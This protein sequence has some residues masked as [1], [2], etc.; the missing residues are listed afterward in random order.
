METANQDQVLGSAEPKAESQSSTP[1]PQKETLAET[2]SGFASVFVAGLFI[3]TFVIQHFEIP[4]GSMEKTLLIGDHVFVDRLTPTGK[5]GI[6]WFLMPYRGPRRGETAV[7]VSPAEPGLYLVKR[8]V[9]VPGDR[10]HLLHGDLYVNGARPAEP[11]VQHLEPLDSYR[12]EFPRFSGFGNLQVTREWA[13]TM[14]RYIETGDLVIPPGHYFAMGD[15]RDHSLDS[16]Y[17][18]LVP[19]ENI[20]GRPLFVAWSLNQD[21]SAFAPQSTGER[22]TSFLNTAVHFFGL[23]RWNRVLRLVH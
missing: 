23:T 15:N 16:R 3:I 12:D 1:A 17:W 19:A 20:M 2:I 14:P 22:L 10:I 8:I 6:P 4:S 18:G 11:Y 21:E 7:F 13:M 5:H 9:A